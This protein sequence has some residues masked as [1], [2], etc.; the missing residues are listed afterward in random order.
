MIM[1]ENLSRLKGE[2]YLAAH[3]GW[4]DDTFCEDEKIVER[5]D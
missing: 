3:K 2:G 5:S 1:E 4:T